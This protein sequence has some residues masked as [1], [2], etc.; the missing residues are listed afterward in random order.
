MTSKAWL[1]KWFIIIIFAIPF[2]I[3]VNYFI[4]PLNILHTSILKENFQINERFMKIEFLEKNNKKYNS[5]MFGSSRIGS[6]NP[7]DIE[8]HI[9]NSKFYNFTIGGGNFNDYLKH[10]DFFIINKFPIENLYLQIDIGN[11]GYYGNSHMGY[12]G[13]FHPH[14]SKESLNVFYLNYLT[15]IFPKSIF[16]KIKRNLFSSNKEYEYFLNTTGMITKS[17]L[18]KEIES[19]C[20]SYAKNIPSFQKKNKRVF[21]NTYIEE[22]IRDLKKIKDLTKNNNINLIV[23]TTPHNKNMMDT[24]KVNDYLDFLKRISEVTTFHD[25][26]GYNSI[27]MDNCNYYEFSHYRPKVGKLIATRIFNEASN[28]NIPDD[29]GTL[30]TKENI[31]IHIEK[32][33]SQIKLYENQANKAY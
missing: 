5:Y 3:G 30:V 2:L 12:L 20:E 10:L 28:K 15:S 32:L 29:F 8:K 9:P 7:Q 17:K 1:K 27:T 25:F 18:E 13:K 33:K 4:D 26:S 22:T 21:S 31:D 19:N 11:M 16:G 23:F 14:V 6:T 24:Y